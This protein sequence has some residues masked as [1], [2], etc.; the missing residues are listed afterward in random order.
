MGA[1]YYL[2]DKD[3]HEAFHLGKSSWT[4]I[5]NSGEDWECPTEEQLLNRLLLEVAPAYDDETTLGY[6]RE[7]A[8]RIVSFAVNRTLRLV[9]DDTVDEF[10]DPRFPE[11]RVKIV[12][13]IYASERT[14]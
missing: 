3:R 7:C 9:I 10:T 13:S 8:K 12:D 11:Q 2:F 5:G 6:F 4:G 14:S 1:T